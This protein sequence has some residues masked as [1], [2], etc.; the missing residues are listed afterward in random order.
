M[1]TVRKTICH[2]ENP[3]SRGAFA[4]CRAF[5]R[6]TITRH[7]PA[8]SSSP[9]TCISGTVSQ[10]PGPSR[11][12]FRSARS[13]KTHAP[14]Q[15]STCTIP[16]RRRRPPR[17]S[18]DHSCGDIS[19]SSSPLFPLEMDHFPHKKVPFLRATDHFP[20]KKPRSTQPRA[21]APRFQSGPRPAA[22]SLLL[23][24]RIPSPVFLG[25]TPQRHG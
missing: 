8:V 14:G 19:P 24:R 20:H 15:G 21:V 9:A 17:P 10:V 4:N 12:I 5:L 3:A 23:R 25:G 22:F 18:R 1:R 11:T 16:R 6:G 13:S 7:D 2:D